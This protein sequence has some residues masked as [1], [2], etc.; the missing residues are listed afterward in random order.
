METHTCREQQLSQRAM[1]RMLE[2]NQFRC[3]LCQG[4][5]V[6]HSAK[7]RCPACG[8]QGLVK[9]TLPAILCAYCSG[10]GEVYARSGIVCTVCSGKGMVTIQH[11][12]QVC[13]S[14]RGKGASQN[15][16]LPCLICRGKGMITAR[17]DTKAS[18]REGEGDLGWIA[19]PAWPV[20]TMG[21]R[22][23]KDGDEE[24]GIKC[25]AESIP[26]SIKSVS[27]SALGSEAKGHL[28]QPRWRKETMTA[29]PA[30]VGGLVRRLMATERARI[31][32]GKAMDLGRY[33]LEKRT[34]R[35]KESR[36]RLKR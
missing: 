6:L 26:V 1:T 15:S 11:P 3:A 7:A 32:G 2:G 13:P 35:W 30:L 33:T 21:I 12:T 28:C 17:E 24:L 5:G 18:G 14:C 29:S 4:K 25:Q 8:G 36:E 31:L 20:I 19:S 23:I 22:A 10:R 16:R 27:L 34:R 9:L